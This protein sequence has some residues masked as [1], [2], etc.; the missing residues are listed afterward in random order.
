MDFVLVSVN[1]EHM[2]LGLPFVGD[3]CDRYY[4]DLEWR[5]DGSVMYS[6]KLKKL[7]TSPGDVDV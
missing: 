7:V 2:K 4:S 6:N 5:E 3:S 1:V